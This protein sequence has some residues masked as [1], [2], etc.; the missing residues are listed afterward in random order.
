[1]VADLANANSL[2]GA[3]FGEV[4]PVSDHR[5]SGGDAG[6]DAWRKRLFQSPPEVDYLRTHPAAAAAY[7]DLKRRLAA[8]G[9]GSAA[10]TDV[11]DAA[12]DLVIVAAEDWAE[13]TLWQ[14]GSTDA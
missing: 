4:A 3:G 13:A 10:Y 2:G 12:C 11:K 5:P 6:A 8:E 1:V 9:R 14:L 7:A